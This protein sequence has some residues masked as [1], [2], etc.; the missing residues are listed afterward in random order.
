MTRDE[1]VQLQRDLNA[2]GYGPLVVD[3]RYGPATAEAY[4]EFLAVTPAP[5][6]AKPWWTSRAI[7]GALVT[8]VI[9]L[10]GL[11]TDLGGLDTGAL[12]DALVSIATGGAG[13]LALWGSIR[14]QAPIDPTLVAPGLRLPARGVPSDELPPN[15]DR[16]AR[17]SQSRHDDFWGN[18]GLGGF[19]ND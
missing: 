18:G 14:R 3:G 10:A 7:I 15:S 2:R 17:S 19:G 9:G 1:I 6:P 16:A 5:V 12:T 11:F 13:L 4:Q 8:L